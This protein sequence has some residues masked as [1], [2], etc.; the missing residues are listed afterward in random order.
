MQAN[1]VKAPIHHKGNAVHD[2]R[3]LQRNQRE[4]QRN[5]VGQ[6]DADQPN[7]PIQHRPPHHAHGVGG[8][9]VFYRLGNH[10]GGVRVNPATAL[11]HHPQHPGKNQHA[12]Q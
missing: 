1:V 2:T 12:G 3:L 9:P 6:H 10:L 5:H 4:H 8:L 7:K 11:K